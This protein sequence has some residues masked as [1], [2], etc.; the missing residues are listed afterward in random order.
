MGLGAQ[1]YR[2]IFVNRFELFLLTSF[3]LFEVS[4][5][6]VNIKVDLG[7]SKE[8]HFDLLFDLLHLFANMFKI[9]RIQHL[10]QGLEYV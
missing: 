7:I 9:I 4:G 8:F 1:L 2:W 3:E 10:F 5:S 6:P